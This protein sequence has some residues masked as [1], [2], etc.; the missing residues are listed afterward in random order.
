MAKVCGKGDEAV[1]GE[2]GGAIRP[3][4]GER[5]NLRGSLKEYLPC[6]REGQ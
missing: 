2:G 3:A 4:W 6:E 5:R 1:L